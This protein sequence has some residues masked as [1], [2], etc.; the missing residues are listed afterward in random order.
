MRWLGLL[1]LICRGIWRRRNIRTCRRAE[2]FSIPLSGGTRCVFLARGSRAGANGLGVQC[3]AAW[4]SR[5]ASWSW[6][7]G[8][9]TL[10]AHQRLINRPTFDRS[11][12]QTA[13]NILPSEIKSF[14]D[15]D[16]RSYRI[17]DT[18]GPACDLGP[19]DTMFSELI[20]MNEI[21]RY[22]GI[23]LLEFGG[24]YG[25]GRLTL[26]SAENKA[27]KKWAD[28]QMAF[29]EVLLN[30]ISDAIAER[31]GGRKNYVGLHLRVGGSGDKFK[32]SSE[33][34]PEITNSRRLSLQNVAVE[35]TARVFIT[36]CTKVYGLD[37]S[38]ADS[39][40]S[41]NRADILHR[42]SPLLP[43]PLHPSDIAH[44]SPSLACP[45]ILYP[46]ESPF[47]T[48]NTPLFVATDSFDPRDDRVLDLFHNTFPCIFFLSDFLS[49]NTLNLERVEEL[50]YLESVVDEDE[51]RLG[52]FLEPFVD[53]EVIAK[54]R[55]VVGSTSSLSLPE[56]NR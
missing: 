19:G 5:R 3:G 33:V 23:K 21:E 32:V 31:L 35:R 56:P 4:N 6:I 55:A 15:L 53:A 27:V 43:S 25:G 54:G 9:K 26:R 8:A 51:E 20:D 34:R 50:E 16:R 28:G 41:S 12:F 36:L 13:L 24:L 7:L 14:P 11:W 40:L 2:R 52:P 38:T 39:L 18:S 47:A 17:C 10:S 29:K 48:L 46:L 44:P 30:E 1:R 49:I 22:D 45:S 42:P 37:L